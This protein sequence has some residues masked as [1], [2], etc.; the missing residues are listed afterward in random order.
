ME[1]FKNM[2]IKLNKIFIAGR[3]E[4]ALRIIRTARSMGLTTTGIFSEPDKDTPWIRQSDESWSLGS[5]P[6]SETYLNN[7]KI[8][9]VAVKSGAGA[10]HPGYGFV[11]EN[12]QFAALCEQ[13]N[14]RFI[15]PS[16]EIL[17]LM[18]D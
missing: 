13:H 14:I 7:E 4:I 10:I 17:K 8:I 5:G 1:Y 3:G 6:L 18:G 2:T 15:G 9:G 12:W 16:V 11:S